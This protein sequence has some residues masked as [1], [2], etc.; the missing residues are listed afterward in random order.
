[1]PADHLPARHVSVDHVPDRDTSAGRT[2]GPRRPAARSSGRRLS[3]D[4]VRVAAVL[5]VMLF[6]G[7]SLAVAWHP[8]LGERPFTWGWPVGASTLL[9]VSGYFAAVAVAR[10]DAW[11]WWLGRLF[12]LLPAFWAAVLVTGYLQRTLAR[13]G[14]W[15]P[16]WSDIG[17]NL[18]MLWQWKPQTY[19]FVDLSYW[20]LPVQ[21]AA[22]TAV[23]VVVRVRSWRRGPRAAVWLWSVLAAELALWPIRTYTA[24]EPFRM[25]H[26]GLGWHRAHLF[27]VG[28]AVFLVAT[29]RIGRVHGAALTAAGLFEQ[30]LQL[31]GVVM[32]VLILL[33]VMG[34]HVAAWGPDWDRVL[35]KSGQRAVRWLAGIS[36]GAY[37]AHFSLG[38]LTMRYLYEAGAGPVVQVLGFIATGIVVGWV[39]TVV[40][41]RPAYRALC[42]RRD[43]RRDS[44]TA[45]G[46]V[47]ATRVVRTPAST[48]AVIAV[49]FFGGVLVVAAMDVSGAARHTAWAFLALCV[50]A[51]VVTYRAPARAVAAVGVAVVCW[52]LYSGFVVP[53]VGHLGWD[54]AADTRRLGLLLAAALLG[55][56]AHTLARRPGGPLARGAE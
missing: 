33:A 17:A 6:H 11:R 23:L 15:A 41:E 42:R 1:M 20:T 25:V 21:L 22:F 44:R 34:V 12:R 54:P 27:V 32:T 47:R 38:I 3:W 10:Q 50:F 37:L 19:P 53:E 7:T 31:R 4:V 9:V 55:I 5:L 51:S 2:H 40:V 35:P 49:A 36:Y 26:D 39:L 30:W 56:G 28:V 13:D 45:V 29:G 46:V 43:R 18:L 8:E 52:L 24:W 16:T 14:W 48:G